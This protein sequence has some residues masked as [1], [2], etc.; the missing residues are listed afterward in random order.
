MSEYPVVKVKTV[1]G[2]IL[3]GLFVEPKAISKTIII[4]IH[5]TSGSFYWNEFHENL[6]DLVSE[7]GIAYLTTNNRGAGVYEVEKGSI[8]C[9]AAVEKFEDCVNDI[10]AWIEFALERGYDN[11]ILEGHS[12]GT[13]KCVYYMNK[14]RNVEKIK[15]VVLLGFSDTVGTQKKYEQ[16]VGRNCSDEAKQLEAKGED[17]RLV[18]D[19]F[20]L[21]GELPISAGTYLNYFSKGS[22]LSKALPFGEGKGLSFFKNIRVPILAVIGDND[23]GEYTIIPI[24]DACTLL[25]SE[26]NLAEVL[27]ITDCGH[28]FE[29][30][31]KELTDAVED[32]IKRRILV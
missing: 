5:G 19:I 3:H 14:G 17:F 7:L 22:E 9:G 29:G 27:Q 32:F 24:K 30:K 16:L 21:A 18:Q 25:Q 12:F 13:E 2:L 28:G 26:N 23:S 4:H 10:D 1:D 11:I 6:V 8:Y 15:G 20:G 31:E